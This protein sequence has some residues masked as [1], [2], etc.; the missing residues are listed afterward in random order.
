MYGLI[1]ASSSNVVENQIARS[2]HAAQAAGHRGSAGCRRMP[3]RP[4][5]G[6]SKRAGH[7][8]TFASWTCGEQVIDGWPTRLS[9]VADETIDGPGELCST[10]H[11]GEFGEAVDDG[12]I[13]KAAEAKAERVSAHCH[14]ES[15]ICDI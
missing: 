9:A 14:V 3:G 2:R 15:V 4:N 13:D 11:G 8:H 12:V 10:G 1:N 6:R 5:R 7:N